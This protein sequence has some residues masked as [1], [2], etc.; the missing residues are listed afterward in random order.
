MDYRTGSGS[1]TC[2]VSQ[3]AVKVMDVQVR[4]A[5]TIVT[6]GFSRA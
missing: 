1:A 3:Q 5:A 2:V 4:K 6:R